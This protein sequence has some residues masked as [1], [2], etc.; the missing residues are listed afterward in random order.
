[1][2]PRLTPPRRHTAHA[3]GG[4]LAL[5]N[6]MCTRRSGAR[7]ALSKRDYAPWTCR[8]RSY[9]TLVV[10]A[11]RR[12]SPA[13]GQVSRSR[14]PSAGQLLKQSATAAPHAS[15][16]AALI[17]RILARVLIFEFFPQERSCFSLQRFGQQERSGSRR[18]IEVFVPREATLRHKSE[19]GA[20]GPEN[21]S[22]LNRY[23]SS[24]K[25]GLCQRET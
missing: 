12:R 20:G 2:A 5:R 19:R 10:R 3:G 22:G 14:V 13:G 6:S 23:G 17:P 21:D 11:A 25:H 1:V 9:G 16:L 18:H 24:K 7:C 4:G 8:V 15:G